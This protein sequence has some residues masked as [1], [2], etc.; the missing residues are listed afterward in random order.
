M[1]ERNQEK[2]EKR[3]EDEV[4]EARGIMDMIQKQQMQLSELVRQTRACMLIL[5]I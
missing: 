4:N 3:E 5:V 2:F 1:E